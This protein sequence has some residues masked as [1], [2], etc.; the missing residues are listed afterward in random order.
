M[1]L[2][3]IRWLAWFLVRTLLAG[4]YRIRV[5]GLEK[6]TEAPGPYLVLPNHPGF[7]DPPLLL[8][9]FWPRFR[10]RP[11][12][13]ETN[14]RNPVLRPFVPLLRSI[15]VPDVDRASV[16]ARSQAEAAVAAAVEALKA[17]DNVILWP[18]GRLSRDGAEHIGGNRS[19]ADIL[20]GA[21]NTTV[22]LMRT[23]GIWGSRFSFAYKA[24][25]PE[26]VKELAKG[27]LLYLANLYVFTPKRHVTVTV[28]AFPPGTRP[29][30]VREKLNPWLE[31]W[32][33]SDVKPG[34]TPTF[35]PYHF[36]FGP[37]TYEY[38]PL[39]SP[40]EV[41]P[42]RIKPATRDAI[43]EMVGER[44]QRPLTPTEVR[45][46]QSLLELGLDS[47]DSMELTLDVERRFGF[48]S[49]V[50]PT[51]LGQL[52]SLA[53]GIS[54]GGPPPR[55]PKKWFTPPT[56]ALHLEV[57][58]E[59]VP[60][61][62]IDRVLMNPHD[63]AA[64]DDR[65]GVITYSDVLMR[66]LLL[67]SKLRAIPEEYVGLLLPASSAGVVTLFALHFA[68]KLP[69]ILNWTTGPGNMAHA[70]R[71]TG[72]KTVITSKAFID[73]TQIEVPGA[74]F[75]FLENVRDQ[76]GRWEGIRAML[77]IKL[78]RGTI[79]RRALSR[80]PVDPERPAVILFTSGSE[81]APKAVPLT[82]RNILADL[83]G[84]AP[85]LNITRRDSVLVFL[86]LFHSFGHTVTGLF[87]MLVG[88]KVVYH[89]D[90]TDAEALVRKVMNYQTTAVAATPTF[91]GYMLDRAQPGDL[92]PLRLVVVG[93]EKCPET[94]F[95]R[96]ASIAPEAVVVEGYGITE[97]SPVISVN[98]PT[99]RIKGTI[100]K[101]VL[102]VEVVA[103][104]LDSGEPLPPGE[105]G[106]LHVTGPIVFP[107]YIGHE[108]E[109][110]FREFAGKR[111]Y[112]T[113]DLAA[114]GEDG[115]IR[116]HGRLKRFIKAAGE[117]ISLPALEEPIS[118]RYPP[119]DDGPRVAV[120]GAE[121]DNGRRIVLFTTEPITLREANGWLAEEGFRGIMRLDEVRKVEAIPV[122]GSGKIDYKVL[123]KMIEEPVR[124]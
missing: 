20:A 64:A 47:L 40:A 25:R 75:F 33:N 19:V 11:M 2:Q 45:P 13:L 15:I 7:V 48:T 42:S 94:I 51:T 31:A 38:P 22:I 67:A 60:E 26:L 1:L 124:S 35:V 86:P 111:W 52:W 18:T 57:D 87:P 27:M 44:L 95:D 123:R 3:P 114:V 110:P 21:P 9:R 70:V 69:V 5:N 8:M 54:T 106:M 99:E 90:P 24:V 91:F 108:G 58:G 109:P 34:E 16:E 85:L 120:E 98:P 100:G 89:P 113:G 4:R 55:P 119:T 105:M 63:I 41:D 53:E 76:I 61:A 37:R 104:D 117:M 96:T 79:A 43:A 62:F 46:E 107:G 97:C 93:A 122:L 121:L 39:P 84:A 82:H 102:G 101:P 12:L 80:L 66:A 112:V 65:A 30:P 56:G 49:E 118:R 78:F 116:F 77:G 23:R 29:E 50:M 17:G 32:Y 28:E 81:K 71:L 74:E 10:F 36:L 92:D 88:V 103:T 83:R 115:Y 73:R 68:N 59:T 72:V 6:A 14:F